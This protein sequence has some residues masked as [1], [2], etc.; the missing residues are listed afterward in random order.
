M[1]LVVFSVLV[2]LYLPEKIFNRALFAWVALGSAFGP[3]VFLRLASVRVSATG[4]LLSVVTGFVLAVSFYLL[5]NTP[6]DILERL[7]PFS[8]ALVVLLLF[9]RRSSDPVA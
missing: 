7:A 2:A 9:S 1:L 3:L 6:G 4:A 5:P 8:A